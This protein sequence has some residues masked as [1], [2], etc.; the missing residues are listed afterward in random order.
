MDSGSPKKL[1]VLFLQRFVCLCMGVWGI[2]EAFPP[3][4]TPQAPEVTVTINVF[5]G[6]RM[7]LGCI[8]L[9]VVAV[10]ASSIGALRYKCSL[11]SRGFM[12]DLSLMV[13][14][15]PFVLATPL[16]ELQ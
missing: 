10:L 5:L 4:N 2:L 1:K 3:L 6:S 7:V 14:P 12:H 9:L 13:S 16:S 8:V 11:G 15:P